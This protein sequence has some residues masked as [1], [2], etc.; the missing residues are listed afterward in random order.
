MTVVHLF[1]RYKRWNP[2]H[3][4]YGAFWGLGVGLGC[5]VGWGPGF[6][7]EVIGYVGAGCGTGFSVGVTFVGVGIGLP[8]SGM[9]N[10]PMNAMSH[11]SN[12]IFNFTTQHAVP[13]VENAAK[14]GWE[15]VSL[16]ASGFGQKFQQLVFQSYDGFKAVDP[17]SWSRISVFAADAAIHSWQSVSEYASALKQTIQKKGALQVKW[18]DHIQ[19]KHTKGCSGSDASLS[20]SLLRVNKCYQKPSHSVAALQLYRTF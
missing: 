8:A 3:P 10:L 15:A 18:L 20:R 4:T 6:G 11:A 1:R 17:L 12:G 19:S 2:V 7:P 16:H 9:T 5:G 13:A 14:Q